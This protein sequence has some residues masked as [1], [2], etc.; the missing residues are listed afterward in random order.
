MPLFC[1]LRRFYLYPYKHPTD[2]T[3][4]PQR[5]TERTREPHRE[6]DHTSSTAARAI[7]FFCFLFGF[8]LSFGERARGHYTAFIPLCRLCAIFF[9]I[10]LNNTFNISLFKFLCVLCVPK[11][12]IRGKYNFLLVCIAEIVLHKEDAGHRVYFAVLHIIDHLKVK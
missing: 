12:I 11:R 5:A 2:T 10:V 9:S 4:A 7:S 3:N 1:V 8:R 6:R